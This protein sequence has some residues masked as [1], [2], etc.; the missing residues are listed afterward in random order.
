VSS[1]GEAIS[2]RALEVYHMYEGDSLQ[3][4]FDC[5]DLKAFDFKLFILKLHDINSTLYLK[6]KQIN[7]LLKAYGM[8]LNI[9]P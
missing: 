5:I 6:A 7:I 9:R 3:L 2:A 8:Y 4:H 1:A